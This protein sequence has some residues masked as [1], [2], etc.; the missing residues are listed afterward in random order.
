MSFSNYL[1]VELLDQIVGKTDYTMPTAYVALFVG[2][3]LDT[4]AGGAEVSGVSY[5]RVTTDGADWNAAAT[6]SISNAE[7]I[8]FPEAG[9][10]WGTITHFAIFDAASAG[11]MLASGALSSSKA[12]GSGDTPKFA[13]G[14][15][16]ALVIT[17]D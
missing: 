2:D 5:A 10:S 17:L 15:P 9:G 1:E 16:G 12:V 8:T 6:G 11:N 3:P 13:G 14:T 7:D 4:G